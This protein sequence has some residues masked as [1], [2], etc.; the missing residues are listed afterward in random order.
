MK[1]LFIVLALLAT[2]FAFADAQVDLDLKK[3]QIVSVEIDSDNYY[4]TMFQ[5]KKDGE[6][7]VVDFDGLAPG[8]YQALIK[9]REY[10]AR[11]EKFD[12]K[13]STGKIIQQVET[14]IEIK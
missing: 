12:E 8:K 3:D 10:I 5:V 2:S 13:L 4:V 14:E 7:L 11:N 6:T 1:N 9:V